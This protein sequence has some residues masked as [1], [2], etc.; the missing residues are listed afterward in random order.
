[1]IRLGDVDGVES[2]VRE[3]ERVVVAGDTGGKPALRAFPTTVDLGDGE[4]LVGYDLS[5]DHHNTTAMGWM[6]TRSFD[7]GRT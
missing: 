7:E 4:V 6:M 5:R 3:V 1:M 2:P